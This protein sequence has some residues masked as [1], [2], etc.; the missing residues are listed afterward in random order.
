VRLC[1]RLT[2]KQSG[3]VSMDFV[4]ILGTYPCVATEF[5]VSIKHRYEMTNVTMI[6][7]ILVIKY[8]RNINIILMI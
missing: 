2:C 7:K 4:Y 5:K 8:H 3:V 6:C 1:L